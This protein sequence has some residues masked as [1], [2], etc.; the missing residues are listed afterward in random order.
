MGIEVEVEPDGDEVWNII[1][2]NIYA[3]GNSS[4]SAKVEIAPFCLLSIIF[5]FYTAIRRTQLALVPCVGLS[6]F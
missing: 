1:S 6:F 3:F 4:C 2:L 5:P